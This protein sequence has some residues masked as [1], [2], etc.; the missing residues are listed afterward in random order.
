VAGKVEASTDP[1]DM[2]LERMLGHLGA[3]THPKP[4]SVLIVGFGAGVT[5]GTFV[6]YTGIERI[7]ICEI[8]MLIPQMVSGYFTRENNDVLHDPRVTV[9]HDDARHYILTTR[10]KFDIITSDPIHPWVKGAATLYTTEYF[11]MIRKHLNPG[12]IMTQWVP[13]YDSTEEVVRSEFAT[14][15][16]TFPNGTVWGNDIKGRGYDTVLIGYD[17]LDQID[18]DAVTDRLRH[19]EHREVADSL[20]EVGF[21]SAIALLS[22]YAGRGPDL[23]LWLGDAQINTDRNLRLQYLAGLGANVNEADRIYKSFRAYRTFPDTLFVGS[24]AILKKVRH[25]FQ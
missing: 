24:S 22:T 3:L 2:R 25:D 16:K 21:P 23:R 11:E 5:A 20:R 8:E 7:V 4:R 9:V 15:F 17:G 10:E 12:G 14:F 1:S 6:L 13:L 18:L 19:P